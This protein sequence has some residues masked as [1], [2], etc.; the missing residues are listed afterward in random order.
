MDKFHE[1]KDC[2][3]AAS[4]CVDP[5]F[6]PSPESAMSS[7]RIS[8]LVAT[9][10]LSDR[11]R[12]CIESIVKHTPEGHEVIFVYN[13]S[14]DVTNKWLSEQIKENQN[15]H[16]VR[17]LD[18]ESIGQG[19]NQGIRLSRGESILLL[20]ADVAVGP[21]WLSGMC[22]CLNLAPES[23][24]VGPMNNQA[25]GIQQIKDENY[26]V[27]DYLEKYA[28]AFWNRYHHRRIPYRNLAAF[29]LLFRRT[30]VE[31][32]GFFD[33]A[34]PS[35]DLMAEDYCLRA[36][37]AGYT[38]YIAGDV[39]VQNH[40]VKPSQAGRGLFEK[41]WT[42]STASPDGRSLL[43]LKTREMASALYLREKIDEAVE[44]L[45]DCIKIVPDHEAIY[46]D[47]AQIFL[48]SKKFPEAAEVI[49]SMPESVKGAL[50]WLEYSG[51]TREGLGFDVE[52]ADYADQMLALHKDYAPALN[53]RGVLAFKNNDKERAAACFRKA[54]ESDPGYGEAHTNLGVLNWGEGKGKEAFAYLRKGFVLSP[55]VPDAGSLYHSVVSAMNRFADAE[56]DFGEA[57]GTYPGSK[58]L[59]FLY[60]DVLLQQGKYPA[61]M[62]R[63]E[64]VVATYGL[65][66]GIMA[67][68]LTV[69]EKIGPLCIDE[70]A[71]TNAL[72]LCMIVKNEEKHLVKCLYSVR[73]IVDEIIIVDTGSTD[74]TIDI[75]KMFGAKVS[76]FPWTGD[77]SEARN[78]S[79]QQATG[80]WILVLDADEVISGRN[81]NEVR[82]L[83]AQKTPVP[84]A[85]SIATR[86]Y[87]QNVSVVGWERNRGEYPE[88][89]G[90]GW[91][92]SDKVRLFPRFVDIRFAGP[93][94]EMVEESLRAAK[95]PILSCK[96]IV[97]HY[98]KLDMEKELK[99]GEEYYYLGKMKYEK[100][101]DNIAY[102]NELAKQAQ[103]LGKYEET[104]DLWLKMISLLKTDPKNY[105]ELARISYG[106]PISETYIQLAAA[107]LMLDRLQE[108]LAA[109]RK[110]MESKIRIKEYVHIYA[111]C[112]IIAG[113]LN[114]ASSALS[115][116][117]TTTP[118]YR[119]AQFMKAVIACLQGEMAQAEELF[120]TLKQ[121]S[122]VMTPLLNRIAQ[123][124]H[125]HGKRD[126]A[127][128]ILDAAVKFGLHD[129]E[130][131]ELLGTFTY[132]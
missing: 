3:V 81:L 95:I 131:R 65:D 82:M 88:E 108:A 46:F 128:I 93:V 9:H 52:A 119:P 56:P 61:A 114:R 70:A 110:A 100:D 25:S 36:T 54:I 77:F 6:I 124:L 57:T 122:V 63:I 51:Y 19:I 71:G 78:H 129:V 29:C 125:G 69:R 102:I 116:L 4:S 67:A 97:H 120:Q 62:K 8:I 53:L 94:H 35:V 60:I 28:V 12:E 79:L 18:N 85:Y 99:K 21:G 42:L 90:A 34:L 13:G 15:Y 48:E 59:A 7:G 76:D 101:P 123:Q 50:K 38:N 103:V 64:D 55:A 89:A 43:V 86:N 96:V 44:V 87:T 84:L 26:R 11:V 83:I 17:T 98:G 68:A 32:I 121:A 47:M 27:D 72:S 49:E 127:L 112:E 2:F 23:G 115:D 118:D 58:R 33:E 74:K 109:A 30:L 92:R 130:T 111:H 75:A 1:A 24:L 31:K 5:L 91:V 105:Q 39:F 16:L 41:K 45:I 22:D 126:D 37:L 104:V 73:D 113:S 80:D 117:L 40:A 107:Y 14:A 20:T 66:E 10:Y 132:C 106:D